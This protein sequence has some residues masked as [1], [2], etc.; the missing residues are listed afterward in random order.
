MASRPTTHDE[1]GPRDQWHAAPE[2]DDVTDSDDAAPDHRRGAQE[3][4]QRE[5]ADTGQAADQVEPVGVQAG[6]L[7]EASSDDL[8]RTGHDGRHG[9]ED[10]RQRD[11]GRGAIGPNRGEVQDVRAA[12]VNRYGK[13]GDERDQPREQDRRPTGEIRCPTC[14]Q[15]AHSDAEEGPQQHEVGQVA[16]MHDVRAGPADQRQLQEEH[17]CAAEQQSSRDR[18]HQPPGTRPLARPDHYARQGGTT[19]P[20]PGGAGRRSSPDVVNW[21]R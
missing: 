15:E 21:T 1:S 13:E 6:Q 7:A 12:L 17:Q 2:Q 10:Q 5:S 9:E 8:A 20:V 4:Q 16:Q 18:H 3:G 11:P 14:T 19:N